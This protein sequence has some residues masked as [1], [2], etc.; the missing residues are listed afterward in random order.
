[1]VLITNE[2]VFLRLRVSLVADNVVAHNSSLHSRLGYIQGIECA[3]VCNID[4]AV[5]GTAYLLF[6]G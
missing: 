5:A 4:S 3:S 6:F 2:G 1:M